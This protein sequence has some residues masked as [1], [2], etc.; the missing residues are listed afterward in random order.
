MV[1]PQL[2]Q[3]HLSLQADT[4]SV[5]HLQSELTVHSGLLAPLT[6]RECAPAPHTFLQYAALNFYLQSGKLP[7]FITFSSSKFVNGTY[8]CFHIN[9][10]V[11]K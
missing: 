9:C 1:P 6:D 2:R 5:C 7:R 3:G 11:S 10:A 4:N 8:H